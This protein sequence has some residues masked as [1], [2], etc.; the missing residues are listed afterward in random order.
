MHERV[1]AARELVAGARQREADLQLRYKGLVAE[2]SD[3]LPKAKPSDEI[4]K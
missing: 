1:A 3:L 4:A 2:K